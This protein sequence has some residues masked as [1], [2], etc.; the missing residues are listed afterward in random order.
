LILFYDKEP[1][2]NGVIFGKFTKICGKFYKNHSI[3]TMSQKTSGKVFLA[4]FEVSKNLI[5][6]VYFGRL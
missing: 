2:E 1:P 4:C 6:N 3:S 5:V